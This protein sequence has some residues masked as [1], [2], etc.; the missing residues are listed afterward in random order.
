MTYSRFFLCDLQVHTPADRE[1]RYGNVGGPTPNVPFARQLIAAHKAA[2]VE[3]IAVTDHNRVDW[4]PV[5]REAAD[6]AGVFVFPGAE[7]SVN[8]CH[9]LF[10]WDRSDE[11][12]RLAQQCLS[13]LWDPGEDPFK[14]DGTPK[15]VGKGQVLE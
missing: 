15:P 9:L 3:V 5:L 8:G 11:G 4:Y 12:Y 2:G 6:E 7:V 14:H 1:H 10:V 13:T